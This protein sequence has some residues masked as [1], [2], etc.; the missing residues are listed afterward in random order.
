MMLLSNRIALVVAVCSLG[1]FMAG[2]AGSTGV[3]VG[4]VA[5]GP[6]V[7]YPYGGG[8]MRPPMAGYPHYYYD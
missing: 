3:Y 8:M 7:G 2:C 4:V 5:P 1:L 6:W